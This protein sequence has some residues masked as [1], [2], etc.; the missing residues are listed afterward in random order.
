MASDEIQIR[1]GRVQPGCCT[2]LYHHLLLS[3]TCAVPSRNLSVRGICI[4]QAASYLSID[5]SMLPSPVT[6]PIPLL[7]LIRCSDLVPQELSL[8]PSL[9]VDM[10][11]TLVSGGQGPHRQPSGVVRFAHTH[12]YTQRLHCP[13]ASMSV[14]MLF[15]LPR[16]ASSTSDRLSWSL[17]SSDPQFLFPA[18]VIYNH[19]W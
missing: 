18:F 3:S 15:P 4:L 19:R 10:G 1:L 17:E 16:R 7:P 9:N 2:S 13:P 11:R 6:W 12:T 5:F 14:L 8:N